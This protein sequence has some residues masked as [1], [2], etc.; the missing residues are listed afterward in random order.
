[1]KLRLLV[2]RKCNRSCEGCCNNDWDLMD[3]PTIDSF[4]GYDEILITG[5]E[6][7]LYLKKL[8]DLILNIKKV[9]DTPIYI[10]TALIVA[11]PALLHLPIDGYT[12]TLHDKDDLDKFE[13]LEKHI[14]LNRGE[15]N[16]KSM[17]LNIFKGIE[18]DI[19]YKNWKIK[20]DMVWI[21]DCP[22]PD[23]EEFKRL[24]PFFEQVPV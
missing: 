20:K 12:V 3:L 22:I 5:G 13:T 16:K 9:T 15:Y 17:R 18:P 23:G 14:I 21:K 6:P 7:L 24:Y 8:R 1:M 10:Y 11:I 4:E 2:T 19:Q